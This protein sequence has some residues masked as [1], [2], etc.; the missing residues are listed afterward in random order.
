MARSEPSQSERQ[1]REPVDIVGEKVAAAV[2]A[3]RAVLASPT[4]ICSDGHQHPRPEV[5]THRRLLLEVD[6]Q[7]P[8]NGWYSSVIS[9]AVYR[10]VE[11]GE[12]ERGPRWELRTLSKAASS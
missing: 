3:A 8:G 1:D 7:H 10:L 6:R 4:W 9:L 2:E 11:L 5:F 12:L